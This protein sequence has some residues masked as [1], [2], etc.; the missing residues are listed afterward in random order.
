M[1]GDVLEVAAAVD[2]MLH[3]VVLEADVGAGFHILIDVTLLAVAAAEP[4][5]DFGDADGHCVRASEHA[6][7]FWP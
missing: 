2:V 6:N 7:P 4:E 1:A 3:E 5:I